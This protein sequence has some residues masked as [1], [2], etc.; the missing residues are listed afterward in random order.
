MEDSSGVNVDFSGGLDED[1][2]EL[3]DIIEEEPGEDVLE[4]TDVV[5][6]S[7][8]MEDV[9][10]AGFQVE[11]T[12]ARI[13]EA[14]ERIIERKIGRDIAPLVMEAVEKAVKSEIENIKNRL[15]L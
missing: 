7:A 11:L 2:I 4:L 6:D 12:D 8:S 13:E 3:T 10:L 5:D 1:V 9:S 14:L 15:G